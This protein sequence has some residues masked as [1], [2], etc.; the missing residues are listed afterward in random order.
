MLL[1]ILRIATN[2]L[3]FDSIYTKLVV[4]NLDLCNVWSMCMMIML[5]PPSWGVSAVLGSLRA[6]V[7]KRRLNLLLLMLV[8]SLPLL[9]ELKPKAVLEDFADRLQ[10]HALNIRV[11]EYDKQ[12]AEEADTAVETKGSGRCDALHHGEESAA[13]DDVGAP[14]T[15][16][17]VSKG[18]IQSSLSIW[19]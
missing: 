4:F 9:G 18:S 12:P 15:V 10:R 3:R 1:R 2:N 7:S 5:R 6:L 16:D 17:C 13:D 8:L 19:F 14:A 11:K